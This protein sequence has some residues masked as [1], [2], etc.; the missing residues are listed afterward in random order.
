MAFPMQQRK[1]ALAVSLLHFKPITIKIGGLQHNTSLER[2][3]KPSKC[4]V[5]YTNKVAVLWVN[6][7]IIL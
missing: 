7:Y 1:P 5:F 2:S 4:S 6:V 3:C